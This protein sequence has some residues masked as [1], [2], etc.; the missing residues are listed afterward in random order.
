MIN[1]LSIDGLVHEMAD[2]LD[3]IGFKPCA[4]SDFGQLWLNYKAME[5]YATD[6]RRDIEDLLIGQLGVATESEGSQKFEVDGFVV[7]TVCRINRSINA[8]ALQEI[9][10]ENG[11]SNHLG[12]LFRWKPEINMAAWKQ[13]AP[14]ITQPL[15]GAITAKPGRPSFTI[16]EK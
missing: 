7:K 14:E 2:A 3:Q 11:L 8:D 13:A 1:S 12:S 5:K 15:M 16:E 10:A 4:E 6:R 9:A